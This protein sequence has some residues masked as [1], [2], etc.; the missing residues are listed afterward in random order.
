M[1]AALPQFGWGMLLL[2]GIMVVSGL[3]LWGLAVVIKATSHGPRNHGLGKDLT[4]KR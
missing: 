2:I 4:P 1:I 3:V